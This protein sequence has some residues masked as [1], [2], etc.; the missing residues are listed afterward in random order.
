MVFGVCLTFLQGNLKKKRR[1]ALREEF[2]S[3]IKNAVD[4]GNEIRFSIDVNGVFASTTGFVPEDVSIYDSTLSIYAGS[5]FL[6]INMENVE[7]SEFDEAWTAVIN[8]TVVLI[9]F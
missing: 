2:I 8:G 6:T 4:N 7:Y 1:I 5:Y 9:E 3:E